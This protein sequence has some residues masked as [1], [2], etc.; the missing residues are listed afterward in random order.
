MNSFLNFWSSPRVASNSLLASNLFV[1]A[2][3]Q[4]IAFIVSLAEWKTIRA[5]PLRHPSSSEPKKL[6]SLDIQPRRR[7]VDPLG[8]QVRWRR[9]RDWSYD[10]FVLEPW[11]DKVTCLS[12]RLGTVLGD[13]DVSNGG[14][15]ST[16]RLSRLEEGALE[17]SSSGYSKWPAA[18][19]LLGLSCPVSDLAAT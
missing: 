3:I 4:L 19:P 13:L 18:T 16:G 1:Y 15:W 9:K 8:S 11:K 6:E 14:A 17:R 10:V 2:I 7:S 12:S 5:G